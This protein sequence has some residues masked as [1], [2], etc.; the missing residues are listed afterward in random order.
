MLGPYLTDQEGRTVYELA[1][2]SGK[3]DSVIRPLLARMVRM[4][5]VRQQQRSKSSSLPGKGTRGQWFK[6]FALTPK[7][8]A[9]KEALRDASN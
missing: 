1:I 4:G 7:G 8:V 2:L 9:R 6:E 3:V 5:L